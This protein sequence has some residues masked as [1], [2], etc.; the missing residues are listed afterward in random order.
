MQELL[1]RIKR[2]QDDFPAAQKQVAAF[3]V[4]N[5]Y[6]IPF[7]SITSMAK[8]IGVSDTTIIK[9]CTQLGFDGFGDFKKIFSDYAYS[10]LTMLNKL[11]TSTMSGGSDGTIF[12][13]VLEEDTANIQATLTNQINR[14][15][16]D[17]FLYMLDKAENI[18]VTGG[19]SSSV[20]AEHM[21]STLRYLGLKIH[22]LSGGV[23]DYLDRLM[24]VGSKDLVIA[25]CFPRY[26][27]LVVSAL[28]DLREAG[29]PVVLFTDTGLSP[30]YPYADVVFLCN[31]SS[32]AYFPSYA[33]CISLI[34]IICRAAGVKRKSSAT[35]HV[36]KLEKR[37]LDRGVFQ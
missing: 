1:E 30:A 5:F 6:Q 29:I 33:S 2:E 34:G 21:A 20:L 35:G 18:Y 36:A 9:F 25:F 26:T 11:S 12:S 16:L 13:E 23:G 4:D 7:L 19:R 8:N 10:E 31:V 22:D 37:L 3:V 27:S 24:M 28:R 15:N 17:R 14:E 32:R